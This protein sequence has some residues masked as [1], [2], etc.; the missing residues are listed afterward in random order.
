MRAVHGVA[1]VTIWELRS[2]S[3][4]SGDGN[5][6]IQLSE[7]EADLNSL[8]PWFV[9]CVVREDAGWLRLE[10][11]NGFGDKS[12][13]GDI[14]VEDGLCVCGGDEAILVSTRLAGPFC[15]IT[16]EKLEILTSPKIIHG[17]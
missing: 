13:I 9:S 10:T 15:A 16:K 7:E 3:L 4:L 1:E 5:G 17:K 11:S 6:L 8:G 12:S 2:H 14:C